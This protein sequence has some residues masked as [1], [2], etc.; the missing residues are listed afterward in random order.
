MRR[1]PFAL[2]IS[3]CAALLAGCAGV[4]GQ[5]AAPPPTAE[6][7]PI[8]PKDALPLDQATV[9]LADATL[10]RAQLPPAGAGGR[11]RL[12]I[13]PLIDRATGA[14]TETTRAMERR[15]VTLVR[16][17]HPQFDLRP[18]TAASLDEKPLILLGSIAPSRRPAAAPT[19]PDR[20]GRPRTASGPCWRTSAPGASFPTKRRGCGRTR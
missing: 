17:R 5:Q 12:V 6:A 7:A 8:P 4:G 15:I 1:T 18:F 16:E 3:V 11:Y 20:G 14:E 19:C 13:D 10:L 2:A 9:A